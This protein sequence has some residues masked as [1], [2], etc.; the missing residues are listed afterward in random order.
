MRVCVCMWI[1]K[2]KMC[3]CMCT[4]VNDG[5]CVQVPWSDF[6]R[7]CRWTAGWYRRCLPHQRESETTRNIYTCVEVPFIH[8]PSIHPSIL[9][10]ILQLLLYILLDI[11][12]HF[13][14]L[15]LFKSLG[16]QGFYAHQDCIYLIRNTVKTVTL[17]NSYNLNNCNLFLF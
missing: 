11:F 3:V 6:Q 10:F 17:W 8:H 1:C 12:L 5:V 16:L 13:F 7:A 14:I 9:F 4:R 2:H 15:L